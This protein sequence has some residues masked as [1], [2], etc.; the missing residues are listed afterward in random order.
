MNKSNS[1]RGAG[2]REGGGGEGSSC[3]VAAREHVGVVVV[4][5][6]DLEHV[7]LAHFVGPWPD[8]KVGHVKSRAQTCP[9]A[10]NARMARFRRFFLLN[11]NKR[12]WERKLANKGGA[13][14]QVFNFFALLIRRSVYSLYFNE[15]VSTNISFE[16][17][18]NA[19]LST[20]YQK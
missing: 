6:R 8:R 4:G 15:R 10:W 17:E 19:T 18:T 14:K 3:S 2:G 12:F 1:R 11:L 5:V 20:H 13:W 9:W 16:V 7:A